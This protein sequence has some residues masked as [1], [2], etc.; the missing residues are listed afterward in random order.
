MT[1]K[2]PAKKRSYTFKSEARQLL[3]L[4]IHSVYSTKEVFLRELISNASDALDKRRFEALSDPSLLPED[5]ALEI[6]LEADAEARTLSISDNGIGMSR[7]EVVANLGTIAR[8]GTKEFVERMESAEKGPSADEL[9]GRFGVGFYSS[10]MVADEVEV[11]TKR[12]G[13]DLAIRWTSKGEGRYSVEPAER[14]A[15]GTT[16]RLHL[17]QADPDNDLPDFTASHVIRQTVKRYSDYVTHPVRLLGAEGEWETVNSM[18]AIWA[19][20]PAEVTEEEH[21]E[22]YKHVGHDWN[23]PLHH[24]R[25]KAEGTFEWTALLYI[26]EAPPFD[27][28][29]RDAD[30]GLQLYSHRVLILERCEELLPP[31]LRFVRGVVESPDL[32]LNV[33]R[34]LLQKDRRVAQIRKRVTKKVVDALDTMRTED[35][36]RYLKFWAAFGRVLKEAVPADPESAD[37]LK[38]LLLFESSADPEAL[39]DLASYVE[40]MPEAQE[41]IYYITG[42]SRAQAERSPHLEALLE[43]GTEVLFWTDPVD[44]FLEGGLG[45]FEGHKLRSVGRGSVEL[46]TDEEREK[47]ESE[48]EAKKTEHA[49]LLEAIQQTLEDH[50]REVRLSTRLTSSPACL[51]VEEG[52]MSPQLQRMLK[53]VGRD[54]PGE[55][56]PILELNGDHAVLAAMQA[57]YEKDRADP[58]VADYAHLLLGQAFL[59]EGSPLPD[60]AAFAGRIADLMVQARKQDS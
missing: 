31:W 38:P 4:M 45:E 48:L 57:I 35:A 7:D 55:Q 2:E 29:Y 6:R 23:D 12:A 30:Y 24:L 56:K 59:A 18:K 36:E 1:A 33:S 19:R 42:E 43:R 25:I 26:P 49:S 34:E 10:F 41:A 14:E 51:V 46:G 60:P 11:L 37:G 50:V 15:A 54:V 28:Y 8:S 5:D 3:D 44:E 22:F 16:V 17:R 13:T 53:D 20:P 27:L 39:T 47:A 32:S 40:R 21:A 58:R 9:I 52:D